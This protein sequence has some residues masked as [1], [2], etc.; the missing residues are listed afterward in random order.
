VVEVQHHR[1][2]VAACA[3]ENGVTDSY[4]GVAWDGAGL[5]DD[6]GVWGGE[7]FAVEETRFDRVAHVRPFRLLGGDA[8]ARE[9][10]RVALSMDW[11]MR[12]ATALEGRVDARVLEPML[13]R[14][15]NAPWSTSVG[16][17]FDAV[18]WLTRV[19][20]RNRFE[21]ESALALEAA[22][23]P[24]VEGSCPFGDGVAGDWEPLVDAIRRDLDRGT[25]PGAI[26]AAAACWTCCPANNSRE[27]AESLG[28]RCDGGGVH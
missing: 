18:A 7:F 24:T 22:I 12:G 5:G 13:T 14:G 10:W 11:I 25:T 8:A 27:S 26:A 28:C 16:R 9:G 1:A 20:D 3:A 19:C 2:H 15:V 17:L 23:D 21:G 6:G 4:L